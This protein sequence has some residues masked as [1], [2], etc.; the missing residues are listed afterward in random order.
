MHVLSGVVKMPVK[1]QSHGFPPKKLDFQRLLPYIINAHRAVARFDGLLAAIPNADILLAPLMKKEAVLSSK[2]E[3][4]QASISDVLE[5]EAGN[6]IK[7]ESVRQDIQE[8]INYRLAM[9]RAEELLAE[10]PLSLRLVK[11]IHQVLMSGVRG[12]NKCPGEF[13]KVPNWIG[14]PGSSIDNATFIPISADKLPDGLKDWEQFINDNEFSESKSP[15]VQIALVHAEF[16]ALHPFLDGNGRVGRILIPILLWQKGLISRPSFYISA[17]FERK[18]SEYYERLLK[19]SEKSEWEE[20]CI[21]FLNCIKEEGEINVA[22]SQQILALYDDLKL[23]IAELTKSHFSIFV[24]DALFSLCI[25][26]TSQV[27]EAAKVPYYS[28][29]RILKVLCDN[30]IIAVNSKGHGR[31]STQYVFTELR[32]IIEDMDS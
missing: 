7:N 4:T 15:L 18:R 19:V 13:R 32:N 6:V 31:I 20:W 25:F 14:S 24:L 21:F 30:G 8:I 9:Q 2:I 28:V 23:K 3:G 26:N 29:S 11:G 16:E 10:L 12:G 5:Y 17:A 22:K 27:A 1:Y